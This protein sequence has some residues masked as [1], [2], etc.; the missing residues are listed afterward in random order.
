MPDIKTV[1]VMAYHRCGE[2]DTL[3]PYEIL[4]HASMVL[5]EGGP[6]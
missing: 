1:A 4:K 5:A 2:Q 3:V 6:P